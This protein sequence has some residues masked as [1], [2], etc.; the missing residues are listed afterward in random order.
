MSLD[1]TFCRFDVIEQALRDV[2]A[3]YFA[4]IGGVS[5]ATLAEM[6]LHRGIS[7]VGSDPVASETTERLRHMGARIY[8]QHDAAQLDGCAALIYTNA[9]QPDNP[10]YL[11]ARAQGIPCFS[12]ADYLGY[13]MR[14]Y[15]H[16]IGVAG[17]HGKSTVTAMLA[18]IFGAAGRNPT[19]AAG[20]AFG[21]EH[22]ACRIGQGEDFIFEACEYRDSFLC[23]YPTTAVLLNAEW[24]HVDYFPTPQA[25][26]ASFASFVSRATA[27]AV[28]NAD[29]PAFAE[30][31][32]AA[33]AE[34]R[35][36]S[37]EGGAAYLTVGDVLPDRRGSHYTVACEGALVRGY[38]PL[39]G[40]HNLVDAAAALTVARCHGIPLIDAATA[41]ATFHGAD[42]RCEY[43]GKTERGC[44]IYSDYAHH[45]TEIRASLGALRG[46]VPGKLICVF[47]SHT[48]S[49]TARLLDDMAAALREADHV[50]VMDIYA[51][52]EQN[53]FGVS[54]EMLARAVGERA[55][56]LPGF[57]ATADYIDR[58]GG[59]DDAVVLMGAGDIL[60]L[61]PLLRDPPRP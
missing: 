27:Y 16:R 43:L 41:L 12:R 49:R 4:G 7:V 26:E 54:G 6:T 30:M 37:A 18:T 40:R 51:A 23:L 31:R 3:V 44:V 47:Q 1:N 33:R 28:L 32:A 61:L 42:R 2:R 15:P 20:A 56:Y 45:P 8:P 34:V 38:L 17:T 60:R 59:V 53:T 14:S 58:Q 52:R 11:A 36:F 29:M 5:M 25:I 39:P 10:E 21:S 19:V 22:R 57:A 35:D 9:L 13:L 24:D 50:V 46:H 55:V 48:Y